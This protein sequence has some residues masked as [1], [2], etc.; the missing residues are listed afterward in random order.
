MPVPPLATRLKKRIHREVAEA[1][2][3]I[4]LGTYDVVPGAVLHGGTSIWRCFG[5]NRFSEDV[6]FYLPPSAKVKS[7]A[8]A[9]RFARRGLPRQK[10]KETQDSLFAR[11]GVGLTA[12]RFEASFRLVRGVVV[13]PYEMVDGTFAAVRTL[14]PE[15]LLREKVA[16]Y[17]DRRKVRDLYDVFILINRVRATEEVRHALGALRKASAK[18]V[19]AGLLG[20]LVLSGSVPAVSDML[21]AIDRWAR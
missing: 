19:D 13:R 7:E 10:L 21:E 11:F 14:N 3:L 6:D 12:V 1:Q 4:V 9:D 17:L 18:P 15:A 16:A 2:D 5:G 8:L 20:A